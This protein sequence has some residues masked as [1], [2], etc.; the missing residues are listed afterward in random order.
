MRLHKKYHGAL[1]QASANH[2]R[3]YQTLTLFVPVYPDLRMHLQQLVVVLPRGVVPII[4]EQDLVHE[5]HGAVREQ[6]CSGLAHLLP[7]LVQ[8]WY[9]QGHARQRLHVVA[10]TYALPVPNLRRRGERDQQLCRPRH[11]FVLHTSQVPVAAAGAAVL[12]PPPA[13]HVVCEGLMQLLAPREGAEARRARANAAFNN[14]P[15]HMPLQKFD[16]EAYRQQAD[17]NEG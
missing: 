7:G 16:Q 13:P 8:V 5:L 14:A 3:A 1:H 15:K 12:A 10:P 17:D 9:N 11:I 6:R 4:H 2:F